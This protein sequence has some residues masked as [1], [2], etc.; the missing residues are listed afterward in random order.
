MKNNTEDEGKISSEKDV[1][2]FIKKLNDVEWDE[3]HR[4]IKALEKIKKP[5]VEHLIQ[6]LKDNDKDVRMKAAWALGNTG[7][8]R[9]VVHLNKELKDENMDVRN[10]AAWSLEK[11]GRPAEAL[12]LAMKNKDSR[13]RRNAVFDMSMA[14]AHVS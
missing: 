10:E 11:L 9:A 12:I 14:F 1:E 13:V 6:F 3:R 8:E 5:V 2:N 7:D 4:L